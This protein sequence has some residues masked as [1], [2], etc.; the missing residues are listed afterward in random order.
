MLELERLCNK[1][2]TIN[3]TLSQFRK[4]IKNI[5]YLVLNQT[6]LVNTLTYLLSASRDEDIIQQN[7][8]YKT[9]STSLEFILNNMVGFF[10][11]LH[12]LFSQLFTQQL[13]RRKGRPSFF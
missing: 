11:F 12:P 5:L 3:E 7:Q 10:Y 13:L 1:K 6:H 2:Q 4:C 9:K 8:L